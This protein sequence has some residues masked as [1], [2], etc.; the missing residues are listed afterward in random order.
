MR[1]RTERSRRKSAGVVTITPD[2]GYSAVVQN[3]VYTEA[4]EI[5]LTANAVTEIVVL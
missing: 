1:Q 3:Q 4:A 2:S 5:N